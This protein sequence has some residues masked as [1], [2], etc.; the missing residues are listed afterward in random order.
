MKNYK[1]LFSFSFRKYGDCAGVYHDGCKTP[2]CLGAGESPPD[3]AEYCR[4]L[5]AYL[6]EMAHNYDNAEDFTMPKFDKEHRE[7]QLDKLRE[8][9]KPVFESEQ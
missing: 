5:A 9:M 1:T 4:A 6:L 8:I 2:I 7:K 3:M